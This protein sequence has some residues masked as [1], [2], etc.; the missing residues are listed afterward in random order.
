[1]LFALHIKDYET[2]NCIKWLNSEGVNVI[3]IGKELA[4]FVDNLNDFGYLDIRTFDYLKKILDKHKSKIN[5][6][7]NEVLAIHNFGILFEP[8]L[9]LNPTYMLKDFSKSA[10]LILIWENQID[11]SDCLHWPTQ[12]NKIFLDFTETP[13]KKLQYAI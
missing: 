9:K 7:G 11:V 5:S 6:T 1:M 10:S 8:A 4:Y 12:Q 13:L 3:D 2:I